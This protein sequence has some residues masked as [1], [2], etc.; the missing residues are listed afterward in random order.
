[1]MQKKQEKI[2]YKINHHMMRVALPIHLFISVQLYS[3]H[4]SCIRMKINLGI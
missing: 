1:M 4:T 2:D 3:A